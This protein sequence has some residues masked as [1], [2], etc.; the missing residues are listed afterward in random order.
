[1]QALPARHPLIL[2]SLAAHQC[3]MCGAAGPLIEEA[4]RQKV[5]KPLCPLCDSTVVEREA[6]PGR[7]LAELERLDK[8]IAD[9]RKAVQETVLE[10]DRITPLEASTNEEY[11]RSAN[12]LRLFEEQNE[13]TM[14]ALKQSLSGT[15]GADA[16]LASYQ[17]QYKQY[18]AEKR[19]AEEARS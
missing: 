11:R 18:Q 6:L 13:E 14:L 8:E 15:P 2:Q 4:I 1:S 3:G 9:T 19:E 5:A 16:L 7:N 10:L 12:E 17:T